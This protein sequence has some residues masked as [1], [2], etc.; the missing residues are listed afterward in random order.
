MR[1]GKILADHRY[2]NR[3]GVRELAKDI[4]LS[5]ATL[6]RIENGK[7]CDGDSIAKLMI[8]L[9][10]DSAVLRRVKSD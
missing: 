1:L 3:M 9:F 6:N 10:T 7:P 2:A 8:W 5:A 4:G